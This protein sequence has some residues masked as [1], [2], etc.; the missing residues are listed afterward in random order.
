MASLLEGAESLF[1]IRKICAIR[2]KCYSVNEEMTD[3]IRKLAS[4]L[5]GAKNINANVSQR[6]HYFTVT[7][8]ELDAIL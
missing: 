8:K 5:V 2:Y 4:C 1:H 7:G 6:W 3:S